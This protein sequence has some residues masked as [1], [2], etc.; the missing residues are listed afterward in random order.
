M[1]S[2]WLYLDDVTVYSTTFEEHTQH[3]KIVFKAVH[4][5]QLSLNLEKCHFYLRQI[6]F[7]GHIVG[8]KGILPDDDKLAVVRD[9]PRP[10]SVRQVRGFL[11]YAPIIE[12]LLK[13]FQQRPSH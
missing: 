3:L 1:E 11:G 13:I 2:L 4:E 12:N 5:A 7:L 9:F 10:I 8:Q 6:K